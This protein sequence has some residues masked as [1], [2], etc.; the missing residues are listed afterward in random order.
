M[1]EASIGIRHAT[2]Y[3]DHIPNADKKS[4]ETPPQ[5]EDPP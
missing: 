5:S 2:N 3:F 4:V 1:A